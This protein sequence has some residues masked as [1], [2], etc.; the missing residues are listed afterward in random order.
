V[1]SW[2]VYTDAVGAQFGSAREIVTAHA[3]FDTIATI[4][5]Y[6]AVGI[7]LAA[8]AW[9]QRQVHAE[10]SPLRRAFELVTLAGLVV[11]MV[12]AALDVAKNGFTRYVMNSAWSD[13]ASLTNANV[14]LL[15]F[16]AL[17]RSVGLWTLAAASLLLLALWDLPTQKL[18]RALVAVRSELLLLV[19]FGFVVLMLPQTADVIREWRVS[20]TMITVALAVV[21]SMLVRWAS[22]ANLRLQH[23]H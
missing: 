11:L 5:A 23:D 12:T 21:L 17:A 1:L 9:R 14:R 4:P 20:H 18:R 10:A 2:R 3:I 13:P 7:T 15:W 6:V 8:Y 22:V 16:F 19:V